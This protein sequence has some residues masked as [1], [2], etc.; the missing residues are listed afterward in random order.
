MSQSDV[1][2]LGQLVI[3]GLQ[4]AIFI[5]QIRSA[6]RQ[7]F[8]KNEQ[9][10]TYE[11]DSL[12]LEITKLM[13]E[14]DELTDFYTGTVDGWEQMTLPQRR[15]YLLVE[16]NYFHFAFVHREFL[17]KRVEPSYWKLYGDWL[18]QLIK[19]NET[20]LKVH[21]ANAGLFETEFARLVQ[22]KI[23]LRASLGT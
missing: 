19:C 8:A 22:K 1:I 11:C 4:A 18:T 13:F 16:L 10:S 21:K 17:L 7:S 5:L 3:F 20:I 15:M 2:A 6:D 9:D 23:S 14:H 12:Y